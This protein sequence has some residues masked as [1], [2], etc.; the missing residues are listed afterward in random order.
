MAFA[1]A[2]IT[3]KEALTVSAGQ[4]WNCARVFVCVGVMDLW[5]A[6]RLLQRWCCGVERGF[7]IVVW[8]YLALGCGCCYFHREVPDNICFQFCELVANLAT[9]GH[10]GIYGIYV[11]HS[12]LSMLREVPEG[13]SI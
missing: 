4:I 3:M 5:I 11:V 1:N 7:G 8:F 13:R 9:S 6:V 2:P 12:F 10:E